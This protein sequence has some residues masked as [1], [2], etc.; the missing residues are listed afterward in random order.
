MINSLVLL[1]V[2]IAALFLSQGAQATAGLAAVL[3]L[4]IG[5]VI[6]FFAFVHSHLISRERLE[7][8]EMQALDQSRGDQSLFAGAA[9]DAY[10]AHNARR[11]FEK[12]VVPG[13]TVLVLLG[14]ALGLL[15]LY[16]ELTGNVESGDAGDRVLSIMFFALFMIVLFMMGKYSAGL[17]RMDGQELLR[18]T[19]NYMLL[20]SVACT[21]VVASLTASH[22][23][24]HG[25]DNV[26]SWILFAVVA[27]AAL[28]NGVTLILEIYRPRVDGKKARLIYDSRLIGLLGQPGGLVSTAAQALDY[29]FGFKVSETW[30]YRYVEQK[31]ALI[32]AVQFVVLFL[33]SSFVVIHSNEKAL[34]ERF[35]KKQE[36]PLNPGFHLKA[37]WPI[38]KVYRYKTDQIQ[39]FTLGIVDDQ[40]NEAKPGG[41]VLLWTTPHNHGSG[42]DQEQNFNMIVASK[43]AAAADTT[44]A[45]P[46]NL[47]T[48]SIPVHYRISDLD[49]WISNNANAGALLQKL[50]M[51][52]LTQFLIGADVD[53]LMGPGR[54]AAQETLKQQIDAEA[55]TQNL[56]AEVLFVGLQDI[57]PP[58]GKSEQSREQGGVAEKY[59]EVIVA[60][61]H[62]ETNRLGAK[63]YS[64]SKVPQARAAAAELLAKARSEST[65]KV[66]I[67]EAEAKRF[68]NQLAAFQ[69]APSVYKTRMKLESFKEATVGSRK[70][71]LSDPAN[72]DVINLELQDQLRKDLLNVTVEQDN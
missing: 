7:E 18:P 54:A 19:A 28:E 31:L 29:Q 14:Q 13:F 5:T 17:A 46:V 36:E 64:A 24:Y 26:I 48:V 22:L 12:W 58:V 1:G 66:A 16:V 50:A 71:I 51:R 44:G 11:Q 34:L 57:H 42:V 8:L 4:G 53:E 38:D 9:E 60:Q 67:A 25:W 49:A 65:N 72:R 62:A 69:S 35:G 63:L 68:A 6:G 10:P 59:E 23:G 47:L 15:W 55:K 2:T 32:L 30:F 20:G 3:L 61:M 41:E 37:P 39:S 43:D 27:I 52:E 40:H 33:S 45:V 56:G 21:A 70:Y